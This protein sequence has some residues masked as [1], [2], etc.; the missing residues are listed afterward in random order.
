MLEQ[1][2]NFFTDKDIVN[3]SSY[4]SDSKSGLPILYLQD[5]KQTLWER[6]HEQ[7]PN[8]IKR[9]AFMIR[10]QGSRYVYKDDLGGLC[11]ECNECGYEVFGEIIALIKSNITDEI[12]RVS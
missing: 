12:I 8:G 10:L 9:T 7:Y 3:M 4:K 5:H 6:F 1:F 11:S 2:E